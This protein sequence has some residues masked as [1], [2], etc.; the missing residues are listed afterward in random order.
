ML[1]YPVLAGSID[2]E[3]GSDELVNTYKTY[4]SAHD[5]AMDEARKEA[6][7]MTNDS[8][9]QYMVTSIAAA[10]G[11]TARITVHPADQDPEWAEF[12]W[13]IQEVELLD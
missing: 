1:I 2:V 10:F 13:T 6:V 7:G 11:N 4:K 3:G 5:S 9:A 8:G 12:W